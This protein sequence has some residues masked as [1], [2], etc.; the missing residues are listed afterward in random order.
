[1]SSRSGSLRRAE[2]PV[3]QECIELD[4]WPDRRQAPPW[5]PRPSAE[6]SA[7]RLA[8]RRERSGSLTRRS[9]LQPVAKATVRRVAGSTPNSRPAEP[10]RPPKG[11]A[12][13]LPRRRRATPS[14]ADARRCSKKS[15]STAINSRSQRLMVR[16][17][18]KK[19]NA[20]KNKKTTDPPRSV[21]SGRRSQPRRF[22]IRRGS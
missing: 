15:G 10:P 11:P 21:K 6:S 2:Y 5:S 20:G 17:R 1:M 12:R 3:S 4:S 8:A 18:I 14:R 9:T 22:L 13:A 16:A 7:R 19:S